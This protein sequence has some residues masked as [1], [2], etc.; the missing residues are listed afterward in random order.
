MLEKVLEDTPK[1]DEGAIKQIL[2]AVIL[3]VH[4]FIQLRPAE[5]A[6]NIY[7]TGVQ[8]LVLNILKYAHKRK[9]IDKAKEP[10]LEVPG[11]EK[12]KFTESL[13]RHDIVEAVVLEIEDEERLNKRKRRVIEDK[14]R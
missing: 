12:I 8:N 13:D 2:E 4:G 9:I 7:Q 1:L 6:R 11:H 5:D 14:V 3:Q 10:Y